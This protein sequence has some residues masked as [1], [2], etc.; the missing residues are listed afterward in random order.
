MVVLLLLLRTG[1][2][3]GVLGARR[4]EMEG[5]GGGTSGFFEEIGGVV[6]R[7]WKAVGLVV[8]AR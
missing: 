4:M 2:A 1:T 8:A 3:I 6:A 5:G 7:G